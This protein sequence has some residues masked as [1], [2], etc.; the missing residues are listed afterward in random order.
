MTTLC[1]GQLYQ[2]RMKNT[3]DKKV[4]PREFREGDLMLKKILPPYNDSWGKWNPNYE[5]PY[6]VKKVF[7]GGELDLTTKDGEKLHNSMNVDA[8]KKYFT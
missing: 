2:K 4:R 5:S 1:H 3:F 6:I 7:S 8:I